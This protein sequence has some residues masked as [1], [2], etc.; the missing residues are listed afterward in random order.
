MTPFAGVCLAPYACSVQLG[1]CYDPNTG[2][3]RDPAT[4]DWAEPPRGVLGCAQDQVFWPKFNLCYI[5]ETGWIYNPTG[6]QAGWQFY[7]LDYTQDKRPEGDAG[8]CAVG[9]APVS[10]HRA[11]WMLIGLLGAAFGLSARRRRS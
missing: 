10:S 7:G 9:S 3:V 8:G 1:L 6:A 2:Y 5:P 4:N 11:S